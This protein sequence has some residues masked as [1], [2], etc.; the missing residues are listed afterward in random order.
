MFAGAVDAEPLLR[1]EPRR[2]GLS[3]H[4]LHRADRV[5]GGAGGR[6]A[7][8][9]D[10]GLPDAGG[11]RAAAPRR[12]GAERRLLAVV[13]LAGRAATIGFESAGAFSTWRWRRSRRWCGSR[14]DAIVTGNPLYSLH[15][16]AGL[17]QELG[18]TQGFSSVVTSVWT[19]SV[20]IDKLPVV[21][22]GLIGV[23]IAVW[24]AP[25]RVLVPL[26][27]LVAARVRVRR[28]GRRRRVGDRPLPDGRRDGAAALLRGGDRRLVDARARIE[29]A[30]R[31]DGRRPRRWCSTGRSSPRPR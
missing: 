23:P 21:L 4:L 31:V 30:P 25:R 11:R 22:G 16:T 3:G 1:R 19:Y 28:R 5:G 29:A 10:A 13:R 24:L 2:A 6:K 18:R 14:A 15:S 27:V 26:A 8:A 7:P 12:V 17:A 9:R 20:R